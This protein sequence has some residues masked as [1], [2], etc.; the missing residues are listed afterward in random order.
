M[1]AFDVS[2]AGVLDTYTKLKDAITEETDGRANSAAL[3]RFIKQAEGEIQIFLAN[4]PV[5]PMR[6]RTDI[7]INA[8]YIDTPA[9][10]VRPITVEATADGVKRRVRFVEN[11]NISEA[12]AG[13]RSDNRPYVFSREVDELR[14]YPVPTASYAG[15]LF[16]YQRLVGISDANSSNWLLAEY[17]HIYLAGALYYAYRDQPDIEKAGLMKGIFDE[18][19]ERL[20]MAYPNPGNE[21]TLSAEIDIQSGRL[22]WLTS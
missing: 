2:V 8:E 3:D 7:T 18:G 15:V 11:E 4:N 10:M 1:P 13:S 5:R 6:T 20:K 22:Q 21:V 9:D 16:Y 12:Q 17:P 19:L 14:F